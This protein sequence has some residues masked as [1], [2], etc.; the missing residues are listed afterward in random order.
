MEK[1]SQGELISIQ[2]AQQ[3]APILEIAPSA[4][5]RENGNGQAARFFI[6][7]TR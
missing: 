3:G 1:L 5:N 6:Q 4:D 7:K 2:Y